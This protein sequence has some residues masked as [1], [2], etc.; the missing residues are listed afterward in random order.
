MFFEGKDA[1][2][3]CF[4]NGWKVSSYAQA[5]GGVCAVPASC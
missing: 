3:V 5:L 1:E 2:A 4:G